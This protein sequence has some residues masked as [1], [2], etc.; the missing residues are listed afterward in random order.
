MALLKKV[1]SPTDI[2][3]WTMALWYMLHRYLMIISLFPLECCLFT[4]RK[5]RYLLR[6]SGER[7]FLTVNRPH[8]RLRINGERGF[9]EWTDYTSCMPFS[10]NY[11][12]FSCGM[13]SQPG[14]HCFNGERGFMWKD[15]RTVL[16]SALCRSMARA[17]PAIVTV[18]YRH[19]FLGST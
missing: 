10:V 3:L 13:K 1:S 17:T 18:L 16:S 15:Y 5:P 7:G 6:I 12:W 11:Q 2:L 19:S 8:S 4:S 9:L 14:R